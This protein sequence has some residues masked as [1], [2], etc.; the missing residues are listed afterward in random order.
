MDNLLFPFIVIFV[1]N[2]SEPDED[3][4]KNDSGDSSIINSNLSLISGNCLSNKPLRT[5]FF[6]FSSLESSSLELRTK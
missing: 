4:S 1:V 6:Y 3:I 5:S 2:G